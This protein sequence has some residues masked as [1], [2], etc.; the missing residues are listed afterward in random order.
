MLKECKATA[1]IC[2]EPTTLWHVVPF[3]LPSAEVGIELTIL[4]HVAPALDLPLY[5]LLAPQFGNPLPQLGNP[6]PTCDSWNMLR[7]AYCSLT[8]FVYPCLRGRPR[9]QTLHVCYTDLSSD[10]FT[11]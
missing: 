11:A 4:C 10:S 6:L 5:K 3:G 2:I 1:K 8:C 9:P 7:H